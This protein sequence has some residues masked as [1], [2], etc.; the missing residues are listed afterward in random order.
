M[1]SRNKVLAASCHCRSVQFTITLPTDSL[2]LKVHLCHCSICR[3]TH[4]T[5]CTFHAGLPSGIEPQFI[6]PSS[7]QKL[8]G[9]QHATSLS[10]RYFCS[11]CGCQIGD[12]IHEDGSWVISNAI[13]DA[14]KAD[15]GIWKFATHLYP[16]STRDG[17][18]SALVP[19]V[20]NH[21]LELI[22]DTKDSSQP[23]EDTLPM[24]GNS[25]T[26]LLAQC[27]C[28]GVSFTIARPK[29]EYIASPASQNWLHPQDKRK[30]LAC[31]DVCDDCRLVNG[32]H[33]IG[34]TFVPL[35]HISPR[36]SSNLLIGSAKAYRSTPD[37]LRT[38]CGTCG[39]TVF[40]NCADR[41]E[42]VDVGVGLLRAPEGVMAENWVLWRA[43]RVSWA[44]NGLR[45]HAGF[46][47]GLI[48][49]MKQWG[50]ERDQPQDFVIL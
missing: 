2:P 44:E 42:I 4:G 28:G 15:H 18:L 21:H 47:H 23:I 36:P 17:G 50:A 38:F 6:A 33:V 13:F 22:N 10:T 35:D 3:H 20:D 14:N 26:E 39:A 43:G 16:D 32:T 31:M 1:A 19:T 29:A 37:V 48:E 8:T 46:C 11:T 27:H 30:W 9:Y 45:Y 25:T 12:Q 41:P 40:Y 24:D 34:W 5:L 7:L 49:G